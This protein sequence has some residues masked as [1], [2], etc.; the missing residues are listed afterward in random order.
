MFSFFEVSAPSR[1]F[2]IARKTSK[3]EQML[4][5]NL[6]CDIERRYACYSEGKSGI[7]RNVEDKTRQ[8]GGKISKRTEGSQGTP[9]L[10]K[11]TNVACGMR[12]CSL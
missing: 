6:V 5:S 11:L 10:A 8:G 9:C 2:K 7:S 3:R 4:V 12:A 1:G